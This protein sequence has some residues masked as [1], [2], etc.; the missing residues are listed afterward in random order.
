MLTLNSFEALTYKIMLVHYYTFSSYNQIEIVIRS[1]AVSFFAICSS[2]PVRLQIQVPLTLLQLFSKTTCQ[3]RMHRLKES[4]LYDSFPNLTQLCFYLWQGR[5]EK[6]S[7]FYKNT[8][9]GRDEGICFQWQHSD[10][11]ATHG[12]FFFPM[13]QKKLLRDGRCSR[14]CHAVFQK[15]PSRCLKTERK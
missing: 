5:V 12:F 10:V 8:T 11:E 1:L 4:F 6:V 9:A 2:V 13:Q 15:N 7:F 14:F 3:N